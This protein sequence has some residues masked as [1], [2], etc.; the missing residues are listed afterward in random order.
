MSACLFTMSGSPSR[1]F[2]LRLTAL[3][4]R[5][6]RFSRPGRHPG[7]FLLGD[8]RPGTGTMIEEVRLLAGEPLDVPQRHDG[9]AG[10]IGDVAHLLGAISPLCDRKTDQAPTYR[11][12]VTT[13]GRVAEQ[14]LYT[15]YQKHHEE[16]HRTF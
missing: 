4:G 7:G 2:A 1:L 6:F 12:A 14:H 3:S 13:V 15:E 5:F 11:F 16:D 9:L 10:E 8:R